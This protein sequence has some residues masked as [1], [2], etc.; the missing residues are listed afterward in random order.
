MMTIPVGQL[1]ASSD[2]RNSL[3]LE[4]EVSQSISGPGD[5][6]IACH[7]DEQQRANTHGAFDLSTLHLG[8]EWH[9]AFLSWHGIYYLLHQNLS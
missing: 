5:V 6:D 1:V 3:S 9:L 2:D 8:P 7:A 4:S